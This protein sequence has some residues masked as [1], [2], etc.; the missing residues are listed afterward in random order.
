MINPTKD[1]EEREVKQDTL[2]P[3]SGAGA[4][5]TTCNQDTQAK[6]S[7]SKRGSQTQGNDNQPNGR[8]PKKQAPMCELP[9]TTLDG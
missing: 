5:A 2:E 1:G 4:V 9:M 6:L 3:V 7:I 8:Q